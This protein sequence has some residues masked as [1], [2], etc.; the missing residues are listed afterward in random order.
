MR[1]CCIVKKDVLIVPGD[2]SRKTSS[3]DHFE[4]HAS[5]HAAGHT[6]HARVFPFVT[7]VSLWLS[8]ADHANRHAQSHS[9]CHEL[10]IL[11]VTRGSRGPSRPWSFR[12]SRSGYCDHHAG[13]HARVTLVVTRGSFRLS[14]ADHQAP[15][16]SGCHALVTAIITPV[17]TRGSLR[18]S[19]RGLGGP[20]GR[21]ARARSAA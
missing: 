19:R 11:D 16:H 3:T 14:R 5:R 6:C 10:V 18:L 17:V 12:L 20:V 7:Y 4:C 1:P 13:C 21:L 15:S 2:T 9:G 8:R